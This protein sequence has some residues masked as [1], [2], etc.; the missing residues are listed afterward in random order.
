MVAA[1]LAVTV[2]LSL[3]GNQR[4]PGRDEGERAA[5]KNLARLAYRDEALGPAQQRSD[6]ARLRLHV[7]GFVAVDRVHDGRKKKPRRV[8]ARKAAVAVRRPLHGGTH[9]V[10]I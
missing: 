8:A 4:G 10:A 5:A 1:S 2:A 3:A 7:H 9:A 6:V